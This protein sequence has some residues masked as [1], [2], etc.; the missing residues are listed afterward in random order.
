M[1]GLVATNRDLRLIQKQG[2]DYL[3]LNPPEELHRMPKALRKYL[4]KG[5]KDG[6]HLAWKCKSRD[7]WYIVPH[8]YIPEA[9]IPCMSA[10]W[11]RI[12]VNRSDYTCRNNIIR[13]ACNEKRPAAEW[14]RLALG[15]LSTFSQ[16]SAQLVGR[17]YGGGVLKVEPTE[18]TR[19]A[20]LLVPQEVTQTLARQ[21]DSLLRQNEHAAATAAVDSA[22]ITTNRNFSKVKLALLRSTRDKLF[23]RRRQHR[24]DAKKIVQAD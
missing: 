4:E 13:L 6:V 7:P 8:T 12:M 2:K 24:N 1:R 18:L 22:L 19:L 3:L 11:P 14:T 21:V 17:S 15:T 16:L 23:M 9:F 20:I 10:S 5:K